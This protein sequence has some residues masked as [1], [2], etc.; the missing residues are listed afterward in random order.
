MGETRI[1]AAYQQLEPNERTTPYVLTRNDRRSFLF[2]N[3][4]REGREEGRREGEA[5]GLA[6]AVLELLRQ[7]GLEPGEAIEATLLAC[8]DLPSLQRWVTR[9]ATITRLDDLFVE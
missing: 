4:Q 9:A 6:R 5:I 8:R 3:G 7:R 1:M 2:V